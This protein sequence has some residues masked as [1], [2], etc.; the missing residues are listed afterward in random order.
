MLHDIRVVLQILTAVLSVANIVMA[1]YAVVVDNQGL[2]D[3]EPLLNFSLCAA[4]LCLMGLPFAGGQRVLDV[5]AVSLSTGHLVVA[6]GK[7]WRRRSFALFE[8]IVHCSFA[9]LLLRLAR[10][11]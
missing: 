6:A 8:A 3:F 4:L 2:L 7:I 5:L 9:I 10:L 11:L 1:V